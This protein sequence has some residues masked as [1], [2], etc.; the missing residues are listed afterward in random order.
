MLLAPLRTC[1]GWRLVEP[2]L[3]LTS[4]GAFL[5]GAAITDEQLR[6]IKEVASDLII[7]DDKVLTSL[8]MLSGIERVGGNVEIR[9]NSALVDFSGLSGL[10]VVGGSLNII[11]NRGV[12]QLVGFTDLKVIGK[13]LRVHH[14][15][16]L[17]NVEGFDSL[18]RVG[19][20]LTIR[21]NGRL[22]CMPRYLPAFLDV[23]RLWSFASREFMP[24]N[25]G[26]EAG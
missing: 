7:T 4:S 3:I 25:A 24:R 23:C 12:Q 1:F 8:D 22:Q 2:E 10:Q 14:N 13:S 21:G 16:Q 9:Y 11:G 20:D 26:L 18:A 15:E 19:Q 6:S 17:A 5:Y